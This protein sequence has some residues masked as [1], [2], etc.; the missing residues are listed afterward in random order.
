M[1]VAGLVALLAA[2]RAAPPGDAVARLPGYG[3][4]PTPMYSGYLDA[5]AGCPA[6]NGACRLHYWLALADDA[7]DHDPGAPR[8]VVLW[9][10]GGPGASSLLGF[11][12]VRFR[13]HLPS[14]LLPFRC[15]MPHS[16]APSPPSRSWARWS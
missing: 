11:L 1:I 7:P 4:P 5:T 12:Q 9:L 3:R 2:V 15:P 10:N 6:D 13:A 16:V 14:W 8:P